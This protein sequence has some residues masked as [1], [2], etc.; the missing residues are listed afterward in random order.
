MGLVLA[1]TN[2]NDV[3]V[4]VIVTFGVVFGGL[5][6]VIAAVASIRAARSSHGARGEASAARSEATAAREVAERTEKEVKSPNGER[7]ADSIYEMRKKVDGLVVA[8]SALA[9]GQQLMQRQQAEH[10][11]LSEQRF[12][13]VFQHLGLTDPATQRT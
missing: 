8:A 11:M 12:A 9:A 3:L 10:L 1:A 6:S 4:A 13:Q 2:G 7:T 5:G